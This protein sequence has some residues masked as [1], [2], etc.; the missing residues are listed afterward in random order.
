MLSIGYLFGVELVVEVLV[1]G[2]ELKLVSV[3]RGWRF[4]GVEGFL[5]CF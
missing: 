1:L 3:V 5:E 4:F 2:I